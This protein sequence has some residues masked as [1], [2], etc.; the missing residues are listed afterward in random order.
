MTVGAHSEKSPAV[1]TLMP[2]GI[3]TGS[4]MHLGG[5]LVRQYV[6]RPGD[7]ELAATGLA[8]HRLKC[9]VAAGLC[10]LDAFD[11]MEHSSR[12]LVASEVL[13]ARL[14]YGMCLGI[15]VPFATTMGSHLE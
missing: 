10:P 2:P 7:V 11:K 15:A 9:M 14:P 1:E 6:P 5:T 12:L 13:Q 3:N 8:F 4:M